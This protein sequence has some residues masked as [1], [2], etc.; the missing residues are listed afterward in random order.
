M[1]SNQ[2]QRKRDDPNFTTCT[3]PNIKFLIKRAQLQYPS[4]DIRVQPKPNVVFEPGKIIYQLHTRPEHAETLVE[5]EW[6][7]VQEGYVEQLIRALRV[8]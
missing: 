5:V 4:R 6:V 1:A 8:A 7:L 3:D 2:K